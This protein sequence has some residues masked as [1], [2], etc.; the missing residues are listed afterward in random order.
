MRM[1]HQNLQTPLEKWCLPLMR[2]HETPWSE[3]W[4]CYMYNSKKVAKWNK[5]LGT[6]CIHG[7]TRVWTHTHTHTRP[8]KH[9]GKTHTQAYAQTNSMPVSK[10]VFK[11]R[12]AR[13]LW[14]LVE[15]MFYHVLRGKDSKYCGKL[16]TERPGVQPGL[17]RNSS[18]CERFS[19]ASLLGQSSLMSTHVWASLATRNRRIAP[20]SK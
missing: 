13:F 14:H 11:W 10:K 1:K 6:R 4:E 12:S 18:E 17:D 15:E 8:D 20:Q 19:L 7:L 16:Q 2:G 3:K 9:K 5:M